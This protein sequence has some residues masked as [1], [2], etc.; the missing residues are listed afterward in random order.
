MGDAN[1]DRPE[2]C[3]PRSVELS[4][5]AIDEREVSNGE[6]NACV[7]AGACVEAP[8]WCESL[9]PMQEHD[10]LPVVCI[11][12]YEASEYCDWVGGRLPSEAEWEK[13]ARGTD[14]PLWPWGNLAPSCA[15]ANF[16]YVADYC[17][18]GVVQVGT[19]EFPIDAETQITATASGFGLLDVTGNAWEWTA[20]WFDAGWYRD[21]VDVDPPSPESCSLDVD[22][23]PGECRYR[24]LRGGA[25]NT[26]QDT[27]RTTTR[28]FMAPDLA[29]DNIGFRC[30]Y[31]R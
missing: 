31:D 16:R 3:P 6:W 19:Y 9:V 13:A 12:W 26:T 14:G 10:E 1:P 2:Q 30:A 15:T 25:W 23:E 7:D 18:G 20:D 28:S 29:D 22:G 4:E 24:V 17:K 27:T 11:S 5:S 8:A 21:S